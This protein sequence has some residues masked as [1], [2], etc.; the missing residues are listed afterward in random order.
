SLPVGQLRPQGAWGLLPEGWKD[1]YTRQGSKG[2]SR[3]ELSFKDGRPDKKECRMTGSWYYLDGKGREK[4]LPALYGVVIDL[5]EEKGDQF[6]LS[7]K[8][9]IKYVLTPAA[10]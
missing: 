9:K 8:A 10:S 6:L 4:T 2:W 1:T 7:G 3:I 5:Q